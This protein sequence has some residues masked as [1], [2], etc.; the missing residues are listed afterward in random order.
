MQY[1]LIFHSEY[2]LF[3]FHW[4]Y[5]I[6]I[7]QAKRWRATSPSGFTKGLIQR[8]VTAAM[9]T[10]EDTGKPRK[11]RTGTSALPSFKASDADDRSMIFIR[12]AAY[13]CFQMKD[14]EYMKALHLQHMSFL[15]GV[16]VCFGALRQLQMF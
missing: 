10:E 6:L 8:Q 3:F 7:L 1:S 4:K 16:C 12:N 15:V 2:L 11:D 14:A 5:L 13:Q 9:C